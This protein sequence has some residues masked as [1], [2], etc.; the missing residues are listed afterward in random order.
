MCVRKKGNNDVPPTSVLSLMI[1]D[2]RREP[3]SIYETVQTCFVM[4]RIPRNFHKLSKFNEY[5]ARKGI[6]SSWF[7]SQLPLYEY[8]SLRKIPCYAVTLVSIP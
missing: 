8:S 6:V 7:L 2:S 3:V 1:I 5:I 4:S